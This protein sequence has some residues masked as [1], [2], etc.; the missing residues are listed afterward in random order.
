MYERVYWAAPGAGRHL[1]DRHQATR[2]HRHAGRLQDEDRREDQCLADL[3]QVQ[4][5]SVRNAYVC[6]I[7]FA[8]KQSLTQVAAV[9]ESQ[10]RRPE[11]R[12]GEDRH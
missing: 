2:T 8:S 11:H 3:H 7:S 5:D 1:A 12:L 9:V 10:V 6:G 4:Y